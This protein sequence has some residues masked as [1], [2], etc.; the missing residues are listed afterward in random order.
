M[1]PTDYVILVPPSICSLTGGTAKRSCSPAIARARLVS[2]N[3]DDGDDDDDDDD[4]EE[5]EEDEDED[6]AA[7]DDCGGG[8]PTSQNPCAGTVPIKQNEFRLMK[9]TFS[10]RKCE[11]RP[12]AAP[13][14]FG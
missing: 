5:E 13:S 3:G 10:D 14:D 12:S 9:Y 6:D 8:L 2:G 7:D 4:E 11:P 1:I